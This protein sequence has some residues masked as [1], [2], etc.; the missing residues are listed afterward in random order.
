MGLIINVIVIILLTL[1]VSFR[2][3]AGG[4]RSISSISQGVTELMRSCVVGLS[5]GKRCK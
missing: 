5:R 1:G 4:E 3:L 2:G